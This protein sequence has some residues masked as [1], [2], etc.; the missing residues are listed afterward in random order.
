MEQTLNLIL[1]GI[2]LINIIVQS[3]NQN[4]SAVCGWVT[5]L[6]FLLAIRITISSY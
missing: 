2:I 4:G 3:Y 6:L 5:A 1:T